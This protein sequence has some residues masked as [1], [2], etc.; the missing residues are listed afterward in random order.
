MNLPGSDVE[1]YL[2]SLDKLLIQKQNDIFR[3]REE[4]TQFHGH[5]KE[6]KDL[7]QK[8]YTLQEEEED[9]RADLD[10]Y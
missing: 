4:I 1:N 9:L 10:D 3:L 5:I 2:I 8:F 6:E 7:S